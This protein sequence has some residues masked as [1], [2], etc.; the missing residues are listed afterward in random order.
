[1]GEHKDPTLVQIEEMRADGGDAPGA[2]A[3]ASL[4]SSAHAREQQLLFL[5]EI[6]AQNGDVKAARQLLPQLPGLDLTDVHE[7]IAVAL[8]RQ[9]NF[10][11]AW[12]EAADMPTGT[13]DFAFGR[14]AQEAESKGDERFAQR[15][16]G[17]VNKSFRRRYFSGVPAGEATPPDPCATAH[18]QVLAGHTSAAATDENCPCWM[19]AQAAVA[20]DKPAL[21]RQVMR[22]CDDS[23]PSDIS[24]GNAHLAV[25]FAQRGDLPAARQFLEAAR[26][27]GAYENG[28]GYIGPS[29]ESVAL[30]W[31]RHGDIQTALQWARSRP[32][33]Y[34]RALAILGLAS[35]LAAARR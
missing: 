26:V 28:E 5:A 25:A 20:P 29:G 31:G 9:G 6:L 22:T 18:R 7:D 10:A 13:S 1:M 8:A 24:D 19:A 4:A 17:H 27:P 11:A 35:A 14:L 33:G 15:A 21:A 2:I 16:W 30:A 23:N 3:M 32:T 34:E 12:Q